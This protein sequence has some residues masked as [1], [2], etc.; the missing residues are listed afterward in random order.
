MVGCR[1]IGGIRRVKMSSI[2]FVYYMYEK[3]VPSDDSLMFSWVFE[4]RHMSECYITVKPMKISYL[5][6]TSVMKIFSRLRSFLSCLAHSSSMS[7]PERSSSCVSC[8]FV[9]RKHLRH[10]LVFGLTYVFWNVD[11]P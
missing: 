2:V 5:V 6:S 3:V 11:V 1:T 8:S 7:D 4:F 9:Y 10:L